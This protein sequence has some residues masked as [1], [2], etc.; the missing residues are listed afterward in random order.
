MMNRQSTLSTKYVEGKLNITRQ[1]TLKISKWK[2]VKERKL[3][4]ETL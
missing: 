4:S 3:W 1:S 2:E